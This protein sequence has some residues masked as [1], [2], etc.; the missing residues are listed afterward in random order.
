M[1]QIKPQ[2]RAARRAGRIRND[3]KTASLKNGR[4]RLSVFRSNSHIYAQLIDDAAGKTIASASSMD[5]LLRGSMKGVSME[6]AQKVG[7]EIAQRAIKAGLRDIYFDRGGFRYQGRV[8]ALADG[9]R[10]GGLNF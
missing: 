2:I 9:A 4:K 1:T 6:A 10:Q 3:L 5:K 8:K 7:E